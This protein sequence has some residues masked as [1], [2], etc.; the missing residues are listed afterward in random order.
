MKTQIIDL[1][2]GPAQGFLIELDHAPLIL[3]KAKHGYVMCGYL[4]IA[5]ANKMGDIAGRVTGVKS[6]ED[7]LKA[8][9]VEVSENAQKMG[10]V[11]G[12]N[13]REFLNK[14]M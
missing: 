12:M 11:S 3:I 10:L 4:N 8:A 13:A 14:L 2:N 1:E 7:V 9:L 5:A 6:Y